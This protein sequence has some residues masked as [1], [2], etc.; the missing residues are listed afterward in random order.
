M[1][2]HY[3]HYNEWAKKFQRN[4]SK[5][6]IK[7]SSN[8]KHQHLFNESLNDKK[9]IIYLIE[10]YRTRVKY[11]PDALRNYMEQHHN[12]KRFKKCIELLRNVHFLRS[13]FIEYDRQ[14]L[15]KYKMYFVKNHSTLYIGII[16]DVI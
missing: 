8:L 10:F 14:T 15:E 7:T 5:V 12:S 11:N 9:I 4:Y 13:T 1:L 3:S 16:C 2:W 6:L